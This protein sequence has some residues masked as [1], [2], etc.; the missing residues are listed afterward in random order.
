MKDLQSSLAE[1]HSERFR[2]LVKSKVEGYH[3][4]VL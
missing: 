1:S 3:Q 2:T 4:Q